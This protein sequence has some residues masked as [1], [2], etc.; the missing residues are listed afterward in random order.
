MADSNFTGDGAPVSVTLD[1]ATRTGHGQSVRADDGS[2]RVR[3][4][5]D[6]DTAH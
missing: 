5:L 4:T 1:G 6:P 3:I 2:V